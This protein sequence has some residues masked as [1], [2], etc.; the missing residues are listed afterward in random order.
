N[1]NA[2]TIT[3]ANVDEILPV[4]WPA[5]I[6][7]LQAFDPDAGIRISTW[8]GLDLRTHVRVLWNSLG[9]QAPD[10]YDDIDVE[11]IFEPVDLGDIDIE[12]IINDAIEEWAR[13][14][15]RTDERFRMIWEAF[16]ELADAQ[17]DII[18]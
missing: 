9:N 7:C 5:F 17:R 1:R 6:R 16:E 8:V 13:D 12:S 11:S 15:C 3:W 2:Q 14:R 10:L 4:T 18:G